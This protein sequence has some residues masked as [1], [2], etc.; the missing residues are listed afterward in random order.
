MAPFGYVSSA[1]GLFLATTA[2]LS[3]RAASLPELTA[4]NAQEQ[5]AQ[6]VWA[7]RAALNVAALQCQFSPFLATVKNYNALIRQHDGELAAAQKTLERHFRRTAGAAGHRAFDQYTTRMYNGFSTLDA[8][9][10][11][12]DEAGRSG[13]ELLATPIGK[14]SASASATSARLRA[15]LVPV[16]DPYRTFARGYIPVPRIPDPCLDK[17]GGRLRRC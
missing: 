7:V 13:R 12:C 9:L 5:S 15:S 17:K 2:S 8:Q 4:P 16:A 6:N 1:V 11:F 14:F 10:G 3:S